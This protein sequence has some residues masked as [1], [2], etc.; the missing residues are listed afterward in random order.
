M[1]ERVSEWMSKGI[2]ERVNAW[3]VNVWVRECVNEWMAEWMSRLSE[4]V[5]KRVREW[6]SEEISNISMNFHWNF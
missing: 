6:E 2:S 4:L 1:S 3:R 5:N